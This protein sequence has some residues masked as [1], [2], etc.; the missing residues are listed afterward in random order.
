MRSNMI[1]CSETGRS[2]GTPKSSGNIVGSDVRERER[3]RRGGVKGSDVRERER[4][5]ERERKREKGGGG[6]KG[7]DVREGR[8]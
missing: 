1:L 2:S 8:F 7:S 5:R 3:E 6:V 4:E